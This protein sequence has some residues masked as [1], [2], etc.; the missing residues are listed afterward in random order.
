MVENEIV[1]L[2]LVTLL[3]GKCKVRSIV[4]VQVVVE[5]CNRATTLF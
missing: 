5:E 1:A 3:T 2:T 4:V